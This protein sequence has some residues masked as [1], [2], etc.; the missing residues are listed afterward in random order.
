MYFVGIR[1]S[2]LT[3]RSKYKQDRGKLGSS[4]NNDIAKSHTSEIKQQQQKE[5]LVL[6]RST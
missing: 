4:H 2:E 1:V 6:Q 5:P 3:F